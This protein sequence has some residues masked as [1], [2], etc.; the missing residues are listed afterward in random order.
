MRIDTQ[1]PATKPLAKASVR[2]GRTA[3]LKYRVDELPFPCGADRGRDDQGEKRRAA[4]SSRRSTLGPQTVN[5]DLK[6]TFR[7]R[8]EVGRYRWWIYAIDS[9]GN[10]QQTIGKGYLRVR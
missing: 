9:A 3:A 7:C 1:G 10:K 8:L 5:T 6:A 2:K 4:R